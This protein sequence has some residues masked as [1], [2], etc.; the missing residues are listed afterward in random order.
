MQDST[1]RTSRY[2]AL[3]CG[4]GR[5]QDE[6]A[7]DRWSTGTSEELTLGVV[8]S[9]SPDE[10]NVGSSSPPLVCDQFGGVWVAPRKAKQYS[11]AG[12]CALKGKTRA[13]ETEAHWTDGRLAA[14]LRF[15]MQLSQNEFSSHP[16][17][18]PI[19]SFI[20]LFLSSTFTFHSHSYIFCFPNLTYYPLPAPPF[21]VRYY[22]RLSAPSRSRRF[23]AKWGS[24]TS[25]GIPA[26]GCIT[27]SLS[28]RAAWDT[29]LWL[30]V[31]TCSVRHPTVAVCSHTLVFLGHVRPQPIPSQFVLTDHPV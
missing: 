11:E 3:P 12:K 17:V 30:S 13:G 20:P 15:D 4:K 16:P 7:S 24:M 19:E 26:R 29:Q 31:H 18:S 9:N 27:G 10:V 25:P 5:I 8:G 1:Q 6:N 28:T 23:F 22:S 2:G 21:S 14:A